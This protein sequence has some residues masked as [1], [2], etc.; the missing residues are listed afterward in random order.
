LSAL[1]HAGARRYWPVWLLVVPILAWTA[2]RVFGLERGYPLVGL[3]AFT[4]C[5]AVAAL[6]ATGIAVAL[7]NWAAAAL[8]ALATVCLSAAVLPRAVGSELES[9]AG[10][11]TVTVLAANIHHGTADPAALVALV[12][13][14][15]PDLLSVEE[16]TPRFARELRADDI[17][18]LLPRSHLEVHTNV[19]GTGLYARHPLRAL[20]EPARF[21]F[22]MPRA[23][24]VLPAG[25]SLRVVAVHPY[26]PLRG[27]VDEWSAALGSLPTAGGGVPWV[28]SGDFNATLD[29]A[30]FRSLVGRG[31]RDAAD[32]AG[33]GLEPTWP[34]G[35]TM[36]P[37]I[38]ID[39]V[40]ADRRLGVAA[41]GVLDLPGSDHRA[42][43]A[44]LVLP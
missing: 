23:L 25:R 39:H 24:M 19:S 12:E 28:L 6:L 21:Q 35:H 32:V 18:R 7:R 40:L 37:M 13:R 33:K 11:P 43:Y 26:P 16:L 4:P 27:R 1:S 10:R 36:P 38:A 5:V 20:P 15:H 17:A 9:P 30:G 44:Q 3:M 14:I 2:I 29:L 8:A 42:I 41:Y 31:Y 34:V 22:R